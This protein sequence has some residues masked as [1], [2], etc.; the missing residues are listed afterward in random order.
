MA[1]R[2]TITVQGKYTMHLEL[3][4]TKKEWKS[5]KLD[6]GEFWSFPI[7]ELLDGT[8]EPQKDI[9]Y[10]YVKGRVYETDKNV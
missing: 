1:T 7:E 9:L 8:I 10:W 5:L 4:H 6:E 3:G 2:T